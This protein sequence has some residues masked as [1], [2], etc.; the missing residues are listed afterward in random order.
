MVRVD[1]NKN[2][3]GITVYPN[4]VK[5]NN[6]NIAA[7]GLAEGKYDIVVLNMSGQKIMQR[8]WNHAGGSISMQVDLPETIKAGLYSIKLSGS[9]KTII[10]TFIVQ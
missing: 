2:N 9:E 5:G 1:L 8:S 6:V 7:S 4:P 10:K 3:S